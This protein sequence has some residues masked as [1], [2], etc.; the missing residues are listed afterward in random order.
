MAVNPR[1]RDC[2]RCVNTRLLWVDEGTEENQDN[3]TNP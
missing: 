2:R 3:E 1:K